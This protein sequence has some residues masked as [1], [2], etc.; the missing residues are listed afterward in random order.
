MMKRVLLVDDN[1]DSRRA[2]RLV[3]ESQGLE[4]IE[5]VNGAAALEWLD[6][7]NADLIVTDNQ[8][9]VLTGLEFIERLSA[10]PSS[11]L[12]PIIFLSGNLDE[13]DKARAR[14]A[15]AYA[16][17]NKPCNFSEFLSVVSLAL[18]QSSSS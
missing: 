6:A 12:P 1:N 14:H 10:K 13:S 7:D 9:P 3:L 5:S 4:C 2:L 16:I 17:L 15:G 11:T 8:M 18:D